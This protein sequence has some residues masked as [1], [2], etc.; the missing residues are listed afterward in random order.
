MGNT[1]KKL[2]ADEFKKLYKLTKEPLGQG[3]FAT[4]KKC[5]RRSDGSVFA[6]K[7]IK[8]K[9]LS[10]EDKGI[11]EDEV[12]IMQNVNHPNCVH[13]YE[14]YESPKK[15]YMVMELLQ[16]GE[17]FDTIVA[18]GSFSEAEAAKVMRDLIDAVEYLHS[19]GIVHRDLKPENIIY[20][21]V[22]PEE[23][24]VK[25]TDFG[26]AKMKNNRST[27]NLQTAC[28]TPGYVAPEVLKGLK[29]GKQVDI[30][31]LGVILFILL[32]GYPPFYHEDTNALYDLIKKGKYEFREHYWKNIS[33]DAKNVIRSMLTVDPKQRATCEQL[34]DNPW[35][36]GS[37]SAEVLKDGY[38]TRL[39]LLQA[40]SNMRKGVRAVMAINRFANTIEKLLEKQRLAGVQA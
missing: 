40:R 26:L 5:T 31:S 2:Q 6:V 34:K 17:L 23:A 24:K 13:L 3:S 38:V 19:Q 35:I 30:W 28:G 20:D 29:Y 37:A 16:G 33:D 15:A 32:C 22:N 1:I 21:G 14:F 27:N 7:I 25:I 10:E 36:N 18:K 39:A 9:L 12:R 4:V 11:V 8:L